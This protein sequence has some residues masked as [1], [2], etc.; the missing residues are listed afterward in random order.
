MMRGS[1]GIGGKGVFD[2]LLGFQV[3]RGIS[4]ILNHKSK[5]ESAVAIETRETIYGSQ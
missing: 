4:S 3:N 2:L 5:L 1:I